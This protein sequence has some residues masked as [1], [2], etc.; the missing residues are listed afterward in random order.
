M[1]FKITNNVSKYTRITKY[2]EHAFGFRSALVTHQ[3]L[4]GNQ[5]PCQRFF[6]MIETQMQ[7][8]LQFERE[9]RLSHETLE[10]DLRYSP[11]NS[12]NDSRPKS[13]IFR[14]LSEMYLGP[15]Q[16]SMMET[17]DLRENM[18]SLKTQT[19]SIFV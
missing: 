2:E 7:K 1:N 16:T 19:A 15:C 9:K 3:I 8:S 11:N 13:G 18:S 14:M 4:G 5:K 10:Q 12:L 6:Y 17:K